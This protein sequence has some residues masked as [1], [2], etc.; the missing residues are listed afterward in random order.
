M[1]EMDELFESCTAVEPLNEVA[2]NLLTKIM[3]INNPMTF[4]EEFA[5]DEDIQTLERELE[6]LD[7][8]STRWEEFR[9][10]VGELDPHVVED[11]MFI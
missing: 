3:N 5:S 11:I 8:S 1:F 9:R 6:R 10:T 7:I 2:Q 4:N